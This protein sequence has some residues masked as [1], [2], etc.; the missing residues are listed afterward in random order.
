M[1]VSSRGALVALAVA[2]P[3]IL[4]FSR[5]VDK[6]RVAACEAAEAHD[7]VSHGEGH[8]N[9]IF[10]TRE[11]VRLRGDGGPVATGRA[12]TGPFSVDAYFVA[13]LDEGDT[14]H[15]HVIALVH[16]DDFD[17]LVHGFRSFD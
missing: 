16:F 17:W 11:Q 14:I 12:E 2:A 5:H 4:G 10:R 13:V 6:L 7:V 9:G 15:E 1:S 8:R 3:P